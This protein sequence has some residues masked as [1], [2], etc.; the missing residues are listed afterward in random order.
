MAKHPI[1]RGTRDLAGETLHPL[2]LLLLG[3]QALVEWMRVILDPAALA[4]T[5]EDHGV[6][7]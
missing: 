4:E 1:P 3:L 5:P 6:A 2:A 7:S